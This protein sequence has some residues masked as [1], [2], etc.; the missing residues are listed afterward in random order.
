MTSIRPRGI[1]S[2]GEIVGH[3]FQYGNDAVGPVMQPPEQPAMTRAFG[4]CLDLHLL[5][6]GVV[7]RDDDSRSGATHVRGRHR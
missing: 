6:D 4:F 1:G 7:N 5:A 3:T 2:A